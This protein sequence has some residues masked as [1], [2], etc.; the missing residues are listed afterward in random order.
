MMSFTKPEV[1][2]HNVSH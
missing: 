1:H 2:V